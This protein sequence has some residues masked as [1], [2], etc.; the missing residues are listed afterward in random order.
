M[1]PGGP[2][3]AAGPGGAT[4]S[5]PAGPE[6]TAGPGG[7]AGSI[8]FGPSGSAGPGGAAGCIPNVGCATSSRLNPST[9]PTALLAIW[10]HERVG[11]TVGLRGRGG[12]GG[13]HRQQRHGL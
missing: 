13:E 4:G 7:A 9:A 10:A 6:G 1:I 5:I 8:P 11:G 3:R 12:V 2:G